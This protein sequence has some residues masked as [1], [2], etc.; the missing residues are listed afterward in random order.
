[1]EA[2]RR[3][4]TIREEFRDDIEYKAIK[5]R[6]DLDLS[7]EQVEAILNLTYLNL[8]DLANDEENELVVPAELEN[9]V[10]TNFEAVIAILLEGLDPVSTN[11][12]M[13]EVS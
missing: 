12:L 4:P 5:L 7:Q 6:T 13:H 2:D 11:V 9:L 3:T 10:A 8:T 1:M